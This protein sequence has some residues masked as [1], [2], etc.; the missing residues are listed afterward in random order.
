MKTGPT[1][2]DD[3]TRCKET[4]TPISIYTPDEMANLLKHADEGIIPFLAI[5]AFAGLRHAEILRLDWGEIDLAGGLIEVK[6]AKAKTASRRL[7][8]ISPNLKKWL[9]PRHQG[10][11]KVVL[12]EQVSGKLYD[13]TKKEE[14]G[15]TW[16]RNALR[17]LVHLVP[18]RPD[19]ERGPDCL[20]GW[21]LAQ[22]HL[23]QLPGA[24]ETAGCG[25]VVCDRAGGAGE[26][27]PG[28]DG[29]R[30]LTNAL[31]ADDWGST[32]VFHFTSSTVLLG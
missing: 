2:A 20:G 15:M 26:C 21:R 22:N 23:L 17:Q 8:P 11:G 24:G 9:T 31:C 28:A 16:K 10:F 3:L 19:P 12:V 27:H 6:A 32:H 14:V 29:D 25:E 1:E 5:G 18:G 7:V 30:C 4:P 13:L